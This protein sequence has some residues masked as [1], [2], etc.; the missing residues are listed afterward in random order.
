[1][2]DTPRHGPDKPATPLRPG[3]AGALAA[4]FGQNQP[5]HYSGKPGRSGPPKGNRNALRHGLKA[6]QL[7][8]GAK[9]I[10]LRLNAFRRQLED[11]VLGCRGEITLT[12]AALIQTCL[13]WE[14]HACLAQRWL[15]KAGDTLKPADRLAFSREIARASAERDK[16]LKDLDLDREPDPW[17]AIY[18]VE[19]EEGEGNEQDNEPD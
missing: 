18:D 16:A 17:A 10:E 19:T 8:E 3:Q 2:P 9:Y 15:V 5:A 1:M 12:D 6:G 4:G 14:R 13:R 11:S 7:P